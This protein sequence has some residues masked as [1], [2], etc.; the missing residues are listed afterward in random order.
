MDN[1]GEVLHNSPETKL[2]TEARKS[3]W[4][5]IGDDVEETEQNEDE[6]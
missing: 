4:E 2:E 5:N 1:T 3:D 6:P